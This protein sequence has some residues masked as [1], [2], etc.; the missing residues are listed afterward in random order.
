MERLFADT[1]ITRGFFKCSLEISR[2]FMLVAIQILFSLHESVHLCRIIW[3][4]LQN[5]SF[6]MRELDLYQTQRHRRGWGKG[7][8]TQT[9][10]FFPHPACYPLTRNTNLDILR[11]GQVVLYKCWP[12]GVLHFAVWRTSSKLTIH[13]IQLILQ[14]PCTGNTDKLVMIYSAPRNKLGEKFSNF[15]SMKFI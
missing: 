9:C 7:V 13:S 2:G 11:F 14:W 4:I 5:I 1:K 15:W 8:G 3:L 6:V 10:F 12:Y